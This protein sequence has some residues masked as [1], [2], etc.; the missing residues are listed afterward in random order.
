MSQ[1]EL[2]CG[3]VCTTERVFD[4]S[5][6]QSVELD[7]FLPDYYPNIFKLL[8]TSVTP[9]IQSRSIDGARLTFDGVAW[10]RVLF[11][12]EGSSRICCVEQKTPFSKTIDLPGLCSNPTICITPRCSFANG[13]AVNPRRLDIR[14]GISCR[15]QIWDQKELSVLTGGSGSGLQCHTRTLTFSGPVRTAF[16]SFVVTEDLELGSAKPSFGS[17][18]A[19][20][21]VIV[22]TD[23]KLIANKAVCKGA[24]TLHLLYQPEDAE[25]A[26]ETMDFSLPISQIVDLPGLE[27]ADFFDFFFEVTGVSIEAKPDGSSENR[28]L[29]CEFTAS[30][31]CS[32]SRNRELP[33]VDDAYSTLYESEL[34]TCPAS[35]SSVLRTVEQLLTAKNA[36]DSGSAPIARVLDAS[37]RFQDAG[38]KNENGQFLLCGNLELSALCCG[39]DGVPFFLEKSLPAELPLFP[40]DGKEELAFLPQVSVLSTG[41]AILSETRLELQTELQVNGMLCR[42]LTLP[43]LTGI[44]LQ[45]D[46]LKPRDALCALRICYGEAGDRIWDI[47]K[48]YSTSMEAVMQENG[49]NEEILSDRTMLLIPLIDA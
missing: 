14:S 32:A 5:A 11:L 44:T 2:T 26:P 4:S 37:S 8:K 20:R 42:P 10:I 49:L 41:Y 23:R 35:T 18:L 9:V 6:E 15:V 43:L 30:L 47:A 12:A 31:F 28:I 33:V 45:E 13:R 48:T 7:Y 22:P 34:T 27:E 25:A 16:R 40:V 36:V 19:S 29:N 1:P 17:L 24:L 38:V 39:S 21:C 46:V 3:S